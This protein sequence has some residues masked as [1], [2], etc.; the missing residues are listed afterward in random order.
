MAGSIFEIGSSGA[1]A[2]SKNLI[3]LK[4][5]LQ[6]VGAITDGMMKSGGLM[7]A[8]SGSSQE[9]I[10]DVMSTLN[11]DIEET[12]NQISALHQELETANFQT[13][14]DLTDQAT[15]LEYQLETL[16]DQQSEYN[17]ELARTGTLKLESER[18]DG[19]SSLR[20]QTRGAS[21]ML[22]SMGRG[23]GPL[24]DI[25]SGI[26][27]MLAQGDRWGS[28]LNSL[29][30]SFAK[31]GGAV[32]KLSGPMMKMSKMAG[33]LS[34]G[35]AG[36]SA[37]IKVYNL[38]IGYSEEAARK[39]IEAIR[40][41]ADLEIEYAQMVRTGSSEAT[42]DSITSIEEEIAARERQRRALQETAVSTTSISDQI[43]TLGG[44]MLGSSHI[45]GNAADAIR[46]V[47]E[48]LE[49]L[50]KDME[51]QQAA[52]AEIE[53]REKSEAAAQ[54]V[55]DAEEELTGIRSEAE[56]SVKSFKNEMAEFVDEAKFADARTG[57]ERRRSDKKALEDHNKSLQDIQSSSQKSMQQ[58]AAA[59]GK[60]MADLGKN[61]RKE[62]A[63]IP[64]EAAEQEQEASTEYM[65]TRMSELKAHLK[66]YNKTET[67]WQKQRNRMLEDHHDRL[68][69]S[70]AN[71]NVV[72]FLEEQKS[73]EKTM[74][75]AVEDHS[76]EVTDAQREFDEARIERRLD[77]QQQ[78]QDMR[79]Q[80]GER[81]AELLEQYEEDKAQA[82]EQHA[83]SM[84]NDAA[85]VAEAIAAENARYSEQ[86]V[87]ERKQRKV[88]DKER[89]IDRRR[90]IEKMKESHDKEM[91]AISVREKS[92]LKVIRDGGKAQ[93]Q[94]AIQTQKAIV[95]V[96]SKGGNAAAKGA[97]NSLGIWG[98]SKPRV[99]AAKGAII[100]EP[101]V[102]LAG[103]G[104]RPEAVIPFEPSSGLPANM[105]GG[106]PP[107]EFKFRDVNLAGISQEQFDAGMA[108]FGKDVVA[109]VREA[110]MG[111]RQL[112]G[113]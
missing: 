4:K 20:G 106:T 21:S 7:G 97:S 54:R 52:L 28:K 39:A 15:E 59:H 81:R 111:V 9:D 26:G 113:G 82:A 5:T 30:T 57:R 56:E 100:T 42:Q 83:E 85:Q 41:K 84:A 27:D 12:T 17:D 51:N 99:A 45:Y 29:S 23:G 101:T 34:A 55:A 25:T 24:G 79:A 92:A 53:A 78:I 105:M 98:K 95:N 50:T 89:D 3:L 64:V 109:A 6:S 103:E 69:D 49:N 65:E 90:S 43:L 112:A 110:K 96:M 8:F 87:E 67:A 63:E 48:E 22:S 74:R 18:G 14:G 11:R 94:V 36:A 62:L 70:V 88:E 60:A 35:L 37:G 71:N 76:E 91:N 16:T 46:E 77:F 75:R 2:A 31:S 72:A 32:G 107:I 47:D 68:G 10:E 19:L 66:E 108:A 1:K 44:H 38:M 102:L 104:N 13:F 61:L 40:E 80:A 73:H 86:K 93:V 33:P 58:S